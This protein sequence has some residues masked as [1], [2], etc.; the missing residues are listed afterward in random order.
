MV[1]FKRLMQR[2]QTLYFLLEALRKPF[3]K[4]YLKRRNVVFGEKLTVFGKPLVINRGIINIGMNCKLISSS[5]FYGQGLQPV[6]LYTLNETSRINI[7]N[8]CTLNGTSIRSVSHI[9]IGNDCVF[10]PDVKIVDHDHPLSST[11]RHSTNYIAEPITIEDNVWV[12]FNV[13]ILKGIRIGKNSI[14]GAGSVVVKDIPENCIAAGIPA[15][16]IKEIEYKNLKSSFETALK[17]F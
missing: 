12:G 1:N 9:S 13:I 2:K 11:E 14:I 15:K 7:G 6:S 10:A 8:S 5:K 17:E 16:V 3:Y 4:F